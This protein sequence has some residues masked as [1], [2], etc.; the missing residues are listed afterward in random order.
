MLTVNQLLTEHFR[1]ADAGVDF[2]VP[3]LGESRTGYF[4]FGEDVVCYGRTNTSRVA[5]TVE[6]PLPDLYTAAQFEAGRCILPFDA[7]NTVE[8]LRR[9]RYLSDGRSGLKSEQFRGLASSFYYL[10]RPWLPTSVRSQLQRRILKPRLKTKFPKWPVDRTVDRLLENL[11]AVYLKAQGQQK[12]PFIWFWPDGYSSAAIVTH[13]VETTP[14]V[15][16]CSALMDMD[17]AYDIPSA[18]QIIPEDRYS[19]PPSFIDEFRRRG[20]EVNVHDLNHDGR[21]YQDRNEFV[22]RA[23]KINEYGREF[24]AEGFRSGALYRNLEWYDELDFSYDMSVPN[25]AHLEPQPGGC[26]TLMPF[27]VGQILELPVTTIQ[28]YSLFH[29]LGEYSIALWKH[30]MQLIQANHGLISIISHPD[31]LQESRAKETYAELLAHLARLRSDTGLWI[32]LPLE[33]ND[34]WRVRSRLE[35]VRVNGTWQIEGPGKERARLA[36]AHLAQDGIYFQFPNNKDPLLRATKN[37]TSVE[38]SPTK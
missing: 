14:G 11:L 22:R 36:Y 1:C 28:D 21:L 6:Q 32:A 35:L 33:V 18:F 38:S 30:Q 2:V 8:N 27:F 23:K 26:C 9:E 3:S 5:R 17:K 12:I 24:K 20:F 7:V 19:T 31:Y 29:I 15:Q 13:D 37:A 4:L 10:L 34:W 25:I 16:F